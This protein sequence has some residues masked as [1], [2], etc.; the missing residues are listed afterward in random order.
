MKCYDKKA[1]KTESLNETQGLITPRFQFLKI[2]HTKNQ[3]DLKLNEKRQSIDTNSEIIEMLELFDKYFKA[4]I[5]KRLQQ[6][7]ANTLETNEKK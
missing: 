1:A 2:T 5:I 6:A 7:I 3:E 4:V